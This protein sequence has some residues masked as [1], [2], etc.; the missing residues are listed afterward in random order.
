MAFQSSLN[1]VQL[2]SDTILLPDLQNNVDVAVKKLKDRGIE[3]TGLV[4]HVSNAQ[5]RKD[6]IKN[7]IEVIFLFNSIIM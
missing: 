7:T 4:C 2:F 1:L 3:V 6:L 5:H